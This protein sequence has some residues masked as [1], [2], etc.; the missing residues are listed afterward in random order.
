MLGTGKTPFGA[1]LFTVI[2]GKRCFKNGKMGVFEAENGPNE[3]FALSHKHHFLLPSWAGVSP[4]W[5][6]GRPLLGQ[7]YLLLFVGN[8]ALKM[9][10]QG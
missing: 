1:V 7:Y 6:L 2:C 4:C 8:T 5:A 3:G 10:K 9:G